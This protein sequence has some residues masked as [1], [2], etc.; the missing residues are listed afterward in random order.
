VWFGGAAK[1]NLQT[2]A[3][4]K[5]ARLSAVRGLAEWVDAA[6]PVNEVG[7]FRIRGAGQRGNAIRLGFEIIYLLGEIGCSGRSVI[8][9]NPFFCSNPFFESA[10]G[11]PV[12]H[13]LQS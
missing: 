12:V 4:E 8:F 3:A 7:A 5:G 10:T 9:S 6:Q 11:T 1:S 13:G 2:G